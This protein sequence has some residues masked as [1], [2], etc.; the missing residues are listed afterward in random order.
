MRERSSIHWVTYQI[1][2][3]VGTQQANARTRTR[4]QDSQVHNQGTRLEMEQPSLKPARYCG[5]F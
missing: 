2:T 1:A 5:T 4:V 3:V